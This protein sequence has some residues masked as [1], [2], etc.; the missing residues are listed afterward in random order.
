V[1]VTAGAISPVAWHSSK[2][3]GSAALHG[4]RRTDWETSMTCELAFWQQ[5]LQFVIVMF[6]SF[7]VAIAVVGALTLEQERQKRRK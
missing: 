6:I 3:I 1:N 4:Y 5:T 7:G 2:Q